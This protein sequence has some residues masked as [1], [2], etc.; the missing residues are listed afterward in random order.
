MK[1]KIFYLILSLILI[2]SVY[3]E[4]AFAAITS[5]TTNAP[6]KGSVSATLSGTSALT[7]NVNE[8]YD[9]RGFNFGTASAAAG[10]YTSSSTETGAFTGGATFTHATTS[11]S[12]GTVYYFRAYA[13]SSTINSIVYGSE[14]SLLTGI[15]DP[16]N[17]QSS[18]LEDK[19]KISW[20]KGSGAGN[21][22]VRYNKDGGA[23][24]ATSSGTLAYLDNG[25]EVT[26][27]NLSPETTYYFSVWSSTTAAGLSTTSGNYVTRTAATTAVSAGGTITRTAPVTYSDSIV[28][29]KGVNTAKT[30]EVTLALKAGNASLMT[31]SNDNLFLVPLENYSTTKS[32]TLTEGDGIKTIYVKFISPDGLNSTIISANITLDTSVVPIT[33]PVPTLEPTPAPA[34]I[35]TPTP[36][37]TSVPV[38]EK[39]ISQMTKE[40][41]TA[42]IVEIM[43]QVQALQAELP[44][45]K[46]AVVFEVNI[47][48]SSRGD[49]VVKL[50]EVLI[51]E[52]LLSEGLNTGWFGPATKT[53]VIKFQEKYASDILSPNGLSKGNGFVGS[54]T[55]AKLNEILGQ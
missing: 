4:T 46:Q 37:P 1:N 53:A 31:I 8:A 39:P 32:W 43:A 49:D 9:V 11:L 29:N 3:A 6:A 48:Y 51:K 25:T 7:D 26:L 36:A 54:S 38:A 42:K 44:K 21:T 19:I 41:L 14:V 35:P 40:E 52:G 10:N 34:P 24:N 27:Y 22:L 15:D 30:R 23:P 12:K 33:T 20:A 13:A 50:Q 5:V 45:L 28:I 2:F 18:S 55:R 16:S 17:V 47:K